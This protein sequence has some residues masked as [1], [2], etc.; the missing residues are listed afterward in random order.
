MKNA[1]AYFWKR[2]E[3]PFHEWVSSHSQA[4][5][6]YPLLCTDIEQLVRLGQKEAFKEVMDIIDELAALKDDPTRG[7]EFKINRACE[8]IR[9]KISSL[10]DHAPCHANPTLID[11][12]CISREETIPKVFEHLETILHNRVILL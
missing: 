10:V 4:V 1:I 5:E 3:K 8:S 9:R 11:E 12:K 2:N 6:A 7:S